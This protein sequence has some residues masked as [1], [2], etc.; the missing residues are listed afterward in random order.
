MMEH[1]KNFFLTTRSNKL[2][3]FLHIKKWNKFY[4]LLKLEVFF[5]SYLKF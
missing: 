1:V 4:V 5:G 2:Q 3:R